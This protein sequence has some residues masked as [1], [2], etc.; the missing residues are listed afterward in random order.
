M[1]LLMSIEGQKGVLC[2]HG[3]LKEHHFLP[4]VTIC[5]SWVGDSMWFQV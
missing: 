5:Y 1:G 4:Q 3:G 2:E